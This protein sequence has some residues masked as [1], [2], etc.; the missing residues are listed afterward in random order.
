M[1]SADE[2]WAIRFFG[3]DEVGRDEQGDLA[4]SR[5]GSIM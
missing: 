4:A 2:S 5:K 3:S 1:A